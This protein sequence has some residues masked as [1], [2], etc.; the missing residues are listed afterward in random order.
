M[1]YREEVKYMKTTFTV[2]KEKLDSTMERVFDAPRD[3]LW[4]AHTD[5][6]LMAKWWG[7]RKYETAIETY[8]P[9]VGGKWKMV[10]KADGEEHVF[11]G[12]FKEIAEP[13]MLTWTFN[14]EPYPNSTIVETVHF[15]ELSK[16][17]TKLRTVSHYTSI[18]AL[19]GMIGSGME[20]GATESWDRL[21][22]LV[23]GL[24]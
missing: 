2:N 12:E 4:K 23:A 16:G 22:E 1:R 7:P 24:K 10:H 19:E 14:Y 15:E 13:S 8:E 17:K 21:E 9:H 11:F 18:E 6:E 3:L 20:D 5:K